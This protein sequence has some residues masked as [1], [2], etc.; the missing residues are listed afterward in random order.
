MKWLA[1]LCLLC[2]CTVPPQRSGWEQAT[3]A[4]HV[5]HSDSFKTLEQ[6]AMK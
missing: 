2:A 4:V 6:P 5:A 1:L 3:Y